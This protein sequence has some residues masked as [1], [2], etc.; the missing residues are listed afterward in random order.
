MIMGGMNFIIQPFFFY[1][2]RDE[3]VFE[4]PVR[5]KKGIGK[6]TER[7]QLLFKI[8]IHGVEA[9]GVS[10]DKFSVKDAQTYVPGEKY[11]IWKHIYHPDTFRINRFNGVGKA[12]VMIPIGVIC[13]AI[14]VLAFGR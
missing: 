13:L 11:T 1:T 14:T 6:E 8:K 9:P 2:V 10:E 5:N 7:R 4:K 12:I 3:G